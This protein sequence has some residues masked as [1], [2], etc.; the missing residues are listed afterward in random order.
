VF[1][2]LAHLFGI[3]EVAALAAQL[4]RRVRHGR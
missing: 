2:L 3:G 4:K 1:V